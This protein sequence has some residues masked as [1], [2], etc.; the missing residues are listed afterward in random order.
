MID[1][2]R[3][4]IFNDK[5][6]RREWNEEEQDWYLSIVD[7]IEVL[8]GT[9]NPRRYWSDVKRKMKSEGSQL[10]EKIVQ[11]KMTADDGKKRFTDV[12]NSEQLLRIIQSVPSPKAEPFKMWLAKVGTERLDEISD[13]EIA[14]DRAF[15]TYLRKGYSE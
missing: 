12:A 13:P 11:L 9:D 15:E 4:V 8:T 5:Q 7:V 10:Y 2:S 3:I 14:I 6:I 1:E